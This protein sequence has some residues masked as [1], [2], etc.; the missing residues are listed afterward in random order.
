MTLK[1]R[2]RKLALR[3]LDWGPGRIAVTLGADARL[4]PMKTAT[5]VQK[6]KGIYRL[7]PDMKLVAKVEVQ[8]P[9]SLPGQKPKAPP[10][11]EVVAAARK[12]LQEL[13]R[14][15]RPA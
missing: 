15:A 10:A 2:M 5:L 4:D 6:S 11:G 14:C 12:V 8:A 1:L 9:P 13:E 3:S 7:T